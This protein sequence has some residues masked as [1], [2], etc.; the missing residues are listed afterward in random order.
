MRFLIFVL[1]S[2]HVLRQDKQSVKSAEL[3][4]GGWPHKKNR[5]YRRIGESEKT[6]YYV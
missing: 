6:E 3:N 4:E 2:I 1:G 5:G